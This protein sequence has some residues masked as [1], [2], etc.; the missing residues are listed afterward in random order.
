M[1]KKKNTN[2][3]HV[4]RRGTPQNF[5]L[6]FIDE[7]WKTQNIRILKNEKNLLEISSFYTW[8][9]KTTITWGTVH[10]IQSE[11]FF[12][13][14]GPFVYHKWRSYDIWFLRY[15]VGQAIFCPFTSLTIQKIKILKKWKKHLA[16]LSFYTSIINQNHDV[17]FLRYGA[18]RTEF[19][20]FW[21]ILP[22]CPPPPLNN[23]KNQNFEKWKKTPTDITILH[24]CATN[25]NHM[26]YC[27]WDMAPDGCNCYFSFWAIFWLFTPITAQ[28]KKISQKWK[29]SCRYH[30]FTQLHQKLLS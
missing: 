5:L 25:D 12:C 22:R 10:E 17:W 20:S 24:K 1:W 26:I 14:F 4:T 19:F 6:A 9:P 2:H 29:N 18:R 21:T 13:H 3:T 11:T 8:V 7:L 23:P 15:Q 28:K 27:S 30:H 16:I